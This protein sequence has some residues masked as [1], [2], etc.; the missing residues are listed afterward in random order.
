NLPG[1]KLA[2]APELRIV[3]ALSRGGAAGDRSRLEADG[4]GGQ[5]ELTDR[6]RLKKKTASNPWL[7][8]IGAV[9]GDSG[10]MPLIARPESGGCGSA[11]RSATARRDRF[12]GASLFRADRARKF[13]DR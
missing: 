2:R 8:Q 1:S 13:H 12:P 4:R 9:G 3:L 7:R 5:A 11:D 6:P 10:K